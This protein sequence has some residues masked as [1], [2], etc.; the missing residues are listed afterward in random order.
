MAEI[1]PILNVLFI[2]LI[3]L[4]SHLFNLIYKENVNINN[5]LNILNGY[6]HQHVCDQN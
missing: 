4:I 6:I 5:L 3:M 1:I 2:T